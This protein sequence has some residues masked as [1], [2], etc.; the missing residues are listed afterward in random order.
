MQDVDGDGELTLI[1]PLMN[2]RQIGPSTMPTITVDE[3]GYK[4]VLFSSTTETYFNDE[5]NYK[6]IWARGY[7]NATGAEGWG[8]FIDLTSDIVH[9]F[10]ESVYPIL[11]TNTDENIHYIYQ[12]D[13][14]PGI[15]LDDEHAYQENRWTYG[16]LPKVELT[17]S[18]T[19]IGVNEVA[20]IDD[21]K[22][23]QNFPNPFTGTTTVNVNLET[24]ANLSLVVTN[25]TGQKVIE[26]NK[27]QVAAQNHT[28]TI[29]A[30]NLQS[31][32]YFYTVTAGTSQVTRKMIVE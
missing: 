26:L 11:T 7:D 3:F 15:A 18:W 31:G 30:T 14:T 23:S 20:A 6:H 21:S 19:G 10:D 16:M 4:Y 2:Y 17:P 25:M 5:F 27:G 9:I 22:V 28:F 1:D 29:D 24:P 32:I 12:A 8:D 13:V